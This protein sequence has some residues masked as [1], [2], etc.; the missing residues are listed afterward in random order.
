MRLF[1]IE[2]TGL[3]LGIVDV[4]RKLQQ[5]GHN[6]VYW[7]GV[8]T[9]AEANPNDFPGTVFHDRLD[10]LYGRRAPGVNTGAMLPASERLIRSF[11][12][13]ES[14]TLTMMNKLFSAMQVS[15]RKNLYYR[16]LAYWTFVLDT[17]KPD[18]L[19]FPTI[20]HT[21]Y[22]FVLYSLAKRRQ[23]L[24]IMMEPTW[25][26]DRMVILTDYTRGAEDVVR[27]LP[28]TKRDVSLYELSPDIREEFLLQRDRGKDATP[29]FV[30]NIRKKY[31]GHRLVLA[32]L[33]SLWTTLSVH[34][35]FSV[36]VKAAQKL[37][38]LP[39][40]DL[41]KEYERVISPPDFTKPY[42]YFPL[43]YQPER[44][45]SPQGGIFVDQLYLCSVLSASL[46]PGWTVYA[47]E[48]PT[49]WLSRGAG[50]SSYRYKGFYEALAAM[51]NVTVVPIE[52]STYQL[53]EHARAVATITGTAGWE[54]LLRGKPALAFGHPWYQHCPGVLKV[55]D[56]DS[57]RAALQ[58]IAGG[59]APREPEILRYLKAFDAASFHGY[60][61]AD[62]Q[63]ISKLNAASNAESIFGEIARRLESHTT[64]SL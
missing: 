58:N 28:K 3:H 24:T 18:A 7:S 6:L 55:S 25:V 50:F 22:D 20:P 34:N 42:V 29:V 11:S 45:S 53:T 19:I 57:C 52:T 48:H 4:A 8:S 16:Y 35:D 33:R 21:V 39:R 64:R 49:Q 63:N 30:K 12:E 31:S 36:L 61:D 44:N 60:I 5:A 10:A 17:K 59:F 23:I 26:G 14:E 47:K 32:K 2:W 56:T 1:F 46:P 37:L 51:K 43:H 54:A 41:R 62:G 38:L 9:P 15:E 27:E 40:F 13:T